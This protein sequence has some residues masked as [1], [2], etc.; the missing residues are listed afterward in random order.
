MIFN[1]YTRYK[2]KEEREKTEISVH[3]SSDYYKSLTDYIPSLILFSFLFLLFSTSH[4]QQT[5]P[6][7]ST[8]SVRYPSVFLD[9]YADITN[10]TATITLLDLQKTD[11]KVLIKLSME[12]ADLKL[13]TKDPITM[14]ISGGM[15]LELDFS[16]PNIAKLFA[17]DNLIAEKGKIAEFQ[18]TRSLPEGLYL[19]KLEVYDANFPNINVSNVNTNITTVLV[20]RFDP[21]LL[22]MPLNN[23][24]IL[25]DPFS[26]NLFFGWTPRSITANPNIRILYQIKMVEVPEGKNAYDAINVAGRLYPITMLADSGLTFPTFSF[27]PDQFAMS[28]GRTYAWQVTAYEEDPTTG[29]R[30][31]QRFRHQGKS[32]VF[33]FTVQENCAQVDATSIQ[34]ETTGE[35]VNITWD[36]APGHTEYELNYREMGSIYQYTPIRVKVVEDNSDKQTVSIDINTLEKGIQYEF[37]IAAKCMSWQPEI[38]GGLF[39]VEKQDCEAPTPIQIEST[40]TEVKLSW[41][42]TANTQKYRLRYKGGNDALENEQIVE[43]N[44]TSTTLPVLQVGK[45]YQI[46][47]DAVCNSGNLD[48]GRPYTIRPNETG[49]AGGCPIPQ[50]F[51][52]IVDHI[53]GMPATS[54]K[55]SY[56]EGLH[57]AYRFYVVRKD[58]YD[59]SPA[60]VAWAEAPVAIPQVNIDTLTEDRLYAYKVDYVCNNEQISTTP[61][62]FFKLEKEPTVPVNPGTGNCFP[63]ATRAAEAVKADAA[64]FEW[65]KS[66]NAEEY[67]LFYAPKGSEDYKVFNTTQKNT[68]LEDLDISKTH[69][70]KYKIRARC[71]NAKYSLFT[72]TALVDLDVRYTGNCVY[73]G[74]FRSDNQAAREIRLV[75]KYADQTSYI[76]SYREESQKVSPMYTTQITADTVNKYKDGDSLRFTVKNLEPKTNYVFYL[77]PECGTEQGKRVGPLN[78]AT[79]ESAINGACGEGKVLCDSKSQVPLAEDQLVPI[80]KNGT[81]TGAYYEYDK[82]PDNSIFKAADIEIITTDDVSYNGSTKTYSGTGVAKMELD[83]GDAGKMLNGGGSSDVNL[84]DRIKTS[85]KFTNVTINDAR[86]LIKGTVEVTGIELNVLSD[87]Q[88]AKLNQFVDKYNQVLQQL[89]DAGKQ[90]SEALELAKNYTEQAEN[91][92][93]GGQAYGNVKTG[94]IVPVPDNADYSVQGGVVKDKSGNTIA[95]IVSPAPTLTAKDTTLCQKTG[96]KY[97]TFSNGPGAAY[98]FD[99]YKDE[100]FTHRK[101]ARE[102]KSLRYEGGKYY[103]VSAKALVEGKVD[104]VKANLNGYTASDL[105]FK[106]SVGVTYA[107]NAS[108]QTL[109]IPGGMAGDGQHIYVYSKSKGDSVVGRLLVAN[110][111]TITKKVVFVTVGD[112]TKWQNKPGF[113]VNDVKT[114]VEALLSQSYNRI[115]IKYDI[116]LDDATLKTDD[117]WDAEPKD[118]MVQDSKSG[119]LD[120]NFTGEEKALVKL[121]QS[122]I[123]DIDSTKSYLFFTPDGKLATGD[124]QGKMPRG[125][126]LGYIFMQG[127]SV[128]TVAKSV[129]HELGHG[130]HSLAHIFNSDWLDSDAPTSNGLN[131]T[132]YGDGVDLIKY[133]WDIMHDPGVVLG[134][135][136]KDKDAQVLSLQD[137]TPLKTLRNSDETTITFLTPADKQL[138]VPFDKLRGVNF[139]F[140]DELQGIPVPDGSLKNFTF[141]ETTKNGKEVDVLYSINYD[142]TGKDKE[143]KG[144]LGKDYAH[145]DVADQFTYHDALSKDLSDE[146]KKKAV[147]GHM[148]RNTKDVFHG[149][150]SRLEFTGTPI[151]K[152]HDGEGENVTNLSVNG[153]G[154]KQPSTVEVTKGENTLTVKA[155]EYLNN[156]ANCSCTFKTEDEEIMEPIVVNPTPA[157]VTTPVIPPPT[158][159]V[160]DGQ[161]YNNNDVV[162]IPEVVAKY[163]KS[164]KTMY[165]FSLK[166]YEYNVDWKKQRKKVIYNSGSD[167][168]TLEDK[169]VGDETAVSFKT[170]FFD[171]VYEVS[172]APT[173]T[174]LSPLKLKLI[175]CDFDLI[176]LRNKHPSDGNIWPKFI[177]PNNKDL[178]PTVDYTRTLLVGST[179]DLHI[180]TSVPREYKDKI[181]IVVDI[182]NNSNGTD[183]KD[184]DE[185]SDVLDNG[186]LGVSKIFKDNVTYSFNQ[187]VNV[188]PNITSNTK[189]TLVFKMILDDGTVLVTKKLV[190]TVT[191]YEQL[192]GMT[193]EDKYDGNN[194]PASYFLANKTFKRVANPGEILYIVSDLGDDNP[195]NYT[196]NATIASN[197]KNTIPLDC[198]TR[199]QSISGM[200]N[201]LTMPATGQYFSKAARSFLFNVESNFNTADYTTA[202]LC[203]L[204]VYHD[205]ILTAKAYGSNSKVSATQ[206]IIHSYEKKSFE[207]GTDAAMIINPLKK[208]IAG[209]NEINP[210]GVLTRTPDGSGPCDFDFIKLWSKNQTTGKTSTDIDLGEDIFKIN[211]ERSSSVVEAMDS[212]YAYDLDKHSIKFGE[213]PALKFECD[214]LTGFKPFGADLIAHLELVLKSEI[215]VDLFNAQRWDQ[216]QL[217]KYRVKNRA[218]FKTEAEIVVGPRLRWGT[219]KCNVT[220][221]ADVK[222]VYEDLMVV[223]YDFTTE[224]LKATPKANFLSWETLIPNNIDLVLG[225]YGHCFGYD[226]GK[227]E[228]PIRLK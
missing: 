86:C 134:F 113:S 155:V 212:R 87:E 102:Y 138:T 63:P 7:R 220:S 172:G 83:L 96:A 92:L 166:D 156:C 6:V 37:K 110:Y 122:K 108:D 144:Y 84:T 59:I 41:E 79:K 101:V 50:P 128:N 22:N 61:V 188:A 45:T 99:E 76:I 202:V 211:Y 105:T 173:G 51:K 89:I 214:F 151:K 217:D 69:V 219:E 215:N 153:Y 18:N 150:C 10:T 145:E 62:G 71:A 135:F 66:D 26:M 193:I 200:C 35:N 4:G 57:K 221:S 20:Q 46:I 191:P 189:R 73:N 206:R 154:D 177:T 183:T 103:Y 11:Y 123:E 15:P 47:L 30:R 167:N 198:D 187:D 147:V 180:G 49:Y 190:L 74:V 9:E 142:F 149:F 224:K 174:E 195:T 27:T 158:H 228:Y 165:S 227:Y 176:L 95:T 107:F 77:Q 23:S 78:V 5:Y 126:K 159:I 205:H 204:G 170:D 125:K 29:G 56:T 75:W 60:T 34:T 39:K 40:P 32:E 196:I 28:Q 199:S 106:S 93:D 192:T 210:G 55:W 175:G 3:S 203:K 114:K 179:L 132:A 64:S 42:P 197:F 44:T 72:D 13:Y 52:L 88:K 54:F 164:P 21:P 143:I 24:S 146:D 148:C 65:S 141:R 90:L 207:M 25:Q 171:Y 48:L 118:G 222:F 43:L 133:Q 139:Y 185:Y 36:K 162:F 181:K 91:Y 70:Y 8:I 184:L 68:T 140:K 131:L 157:P 182:P 209:Y 67:Q 104:K 163:R 53:P 169:Q 178:N 127:A 161:Q 218:L 82:A 213:I 12:S 223:S 168:T 208:M 186:G 116:E 117:S 120:N 201:T 137:L 194:N 160:F 2:K 100:Y 226:T 129:L 38:Y 19:V 97:V 98:D 112:P 216:K 111:P 136:E 124:L 33:T 31:Y 1:R 14:I 130:P 80:K 17:Y 225:I 115:G 94:S 85:V 119:F 121:Y 152:T 109:S 81:G 58:L 16:D